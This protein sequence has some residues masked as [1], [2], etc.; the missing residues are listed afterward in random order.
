MEDV[1]NKR[2]HC[3][4][5]ERRAKTIECV[6]SEKMFAC[7]LALTV[8]RVTVRGDTTIATTTFPSSGNQDTSKWG[9]G[10]LH[11]ESDSTTSITVSVRECTF[12]ENMNGN[13]VTAVTGGGAIYANKANLACTDCHF[14]RCQART[15]MGGA[16]FSHNVTGEDPYLKLTGCTF[17]ECCAYLN[18]T[19]SGAGAVYVGAAKLTMKSCSFERCF[20]GGFG[21]AVLAHGAVE[22]MGCNF[23]ETNSTLKGGALFL[24]GASVAFNLCQFTKCNSGDNVDFISLQVADLNFSSVTITGG[25]E[26]GNTFVELRAD[27]GSVLEIV[28]DQCHVYGEDH[29]FEGTNAWLTFPDNFGSFTARDCMFKMFGKSDRDNGKGGAFAFPGGGD[30]TVQFYNCRFENLSTVKQYGAALLFAKASNNYNV[31]ISACVFVGCKAGTDEPHYS[32]GGAMFFKYNMAEAR[33]GSLNVVDCS[34][35]Q[36]SASGGFGDNIISTAV[37]H[38]SSPVPKTQKKSHVK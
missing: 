15:G 8:A 28:L 22:M 4:S 36:N 16:I 7:L 25:Q 19:D 35:I 30:Q 37:H 1:E 34:F 33:S 21:G 9:G 32:R 31:M 11:M 10:A 12:I 3:V 38:V 13:N 24:D 2:L 29:S 14:L 6:Q 20:T 23:S 18:N 27:E 26:T 5:I 17:E